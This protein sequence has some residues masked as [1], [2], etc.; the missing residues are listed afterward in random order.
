MLP[1]IGN[2]SAGIPPVRLGSDSEVPGVGT[3]DLPSRPHGRHQGGCCVLYAD[4]RAEW[5]PFVQLV[6]DESLWNGR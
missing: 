5:I 1:A 2:E 3:P 4:G 6:E